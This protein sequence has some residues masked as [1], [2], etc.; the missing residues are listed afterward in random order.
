[1][2]GKRQRQNRGMRKWRE[3]RGFT[4]IEAIIAV[5]VL[6]FGILA[7]AATMADSLAYMKGSQDDYIAQQKAQE[8]L[9]AVFFA[10]N[11]KLYTWSQIKNVSNGGIFLDGPQP[12]LHPGSNGIVGTSL[13]DPNNPDVLVYPDTNGQ[14]GVADDVKL[15]LKNFTRE[16]KI[17]DVAN[18]PNLRQI[19]IIIRYESTRFQRQYTL[20]GY[21]SA[22]S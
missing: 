20:N 5:A 10:R 1:M 7:L 3:G 14:L 9:E 6:S 16:I 12:L 8:A 2:N 18:E 13:D 21:I 22:F 11:S 4:L 15:P 19:Q 17:T